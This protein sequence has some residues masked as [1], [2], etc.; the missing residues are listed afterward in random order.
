MRQ[1]KGHE[2]IGIA[3]EAVDL[4]DRLKRSAD[5]GEA[6]YWLAAGH[7]HAEN[8]DEAKSIYRALL[9]HAHASEPPTADFRGRI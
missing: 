9:A 4:F 8:S 2:A 7:Y 5:A 6:R 3:S 1:R